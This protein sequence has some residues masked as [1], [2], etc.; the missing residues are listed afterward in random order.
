M[1]LVIMSS[2]EFTRLRVIQDLDAGRIKPAHA[3]QLL[4]VTTRQIR[5]LRRRFGDQGAGGLASRQRGK[6]SNRRTPREIR[7]EVL[8]LIRTHYH[9]FGPTFAAEKL[10]EQHRLCLSPETVRI[11]MKNEGLWQERKARKK[12]IQQPRYRR[13]C[14]GE[15]VQI[16]GSEH[17]WFEDRGP[18]CTLLVYIDDATSKLMQLKFVQSESAFSYFQATAEYLRRHGKPVAFY[19]DKHSIFRITRRGAMSGTGMT[20]F[21][22]ALSE[23][24][25]DIICA[26]TPQAKG[27]VERANRTLQDRLVKELRLRGICTMEEANG[28]TADFIE[29][30]NGRFGRA[31]LNDKDLHRP[32]A[33]DDHLDQVFVWREDRTVSGS[34]TLQ[35]DKVLFMLEPNEVSRGLARKR[36]TVSDHPDGRLVISHNGLPLPYKIFDTVRQVTQGAIVDNKR[37]GAALS[38]IKQSQEHHGVHRSQ[39]GPR[40]LDQNDSIFSRP[41]AT[42]SALRKKRRVQKAAVKKAARN[43]A[44]LPVEFDAMLTEHATELSSRLPLHFDPSSLS[45]PDPHTETELW[46]MEERNREIDAERKL[47]NRHRYASRRKHLKILKELEEQEEQPKK[48][49]A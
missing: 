21:G 18:P 34:L 45:S 33:P 12:Q 39:H 44:F 43:I 19:S 9:D 32:L 36:V 25:I 28:Y 23:L 6:P 7:D 26:N 17:H 40:R 2:E 4:G 41:P 13:E 1:G 11:W 5:R 49:A 22:R 37:L 48:L 31:P 20:Q 16:D 27:R 47:L 14:L 8:R 15:L 38:I 3:G 30:F 29:D 46:L 42:I 24:N 10:K 35:Y